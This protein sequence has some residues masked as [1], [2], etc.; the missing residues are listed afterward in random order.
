MASI[1]VEEVL[2][3]LSNYDKI[4]LLAG[5]DFWHTKA[6]PQHGVP[7]LRMTDGPNG[8]RGP[9]FFNGVPAACFPCGTALG[10]LWDQDLLQQAGYLMGEETKAKGAHVILGPTINMQR[11]PLGGRGFES[12]SEDPV[13]AGLAAAS[14]IRGIQRTGVAA[15]L[16]HFVCN[17]QEHG[18]IAYDALIT[19]RALR[20]IYL[21]P[22]Q[23]AIRDSEPLAIMT[24]YNKV[25]GLHN[26]ENPKIMTETLRDEWGWEGAIMSD[27][28]GTYS[29]SDSVNAGLDLEMPGPTKWRGGIL[30]HALAANKVKMQTIDERARKVLQLVD[31]CAK[32]GV[33]ENA[34]VGRLPDSKVSSLLRRCAAESIV[35]LKNFKKV[36]PFSKKKPLLVIGPNAKL[37]NI[38]GGGSA[39]LNPYYAIT[40]FDG[41]KS[42][43]QADVSYVLGSYSHKELPLI[44]TQVRTAPDS[45][46][47]KSGVVFRAYNE[48]PSDKSRRPVDEITISN[49]YFLL[50]DYGCPA[51]KSSLW[52]ATVDGYY[53]AERSGT[54]EL[55]L[56]VSG[57]AQLFV[58]DKL[59]IDNATK[60][61]QGETFFGNGTVEVKGTVAMQ[62]GGT[63]HIH[64]TFASSPSSKL[65]KAGVTTFP[66]GGMRIGGA[67]VLDPEE[68]VH[69]ATEMAREA[70]Q[71]VICAGLNMDWE[72]EGADRE[73]M[74]MPGHIDA[75]ISSV[76]KVNPN[77]AVVL[78]SG[79]P[80][81][82]PWL[83]EVDTLVQAWYGGNETGN[84]IAD[85]LFGDVN[86]SG[87]LPLT[88][89]KRVQDNPAFLN[90]RCEGGRTLYGEDV[91]MGYR[92]YEMLEREVAFPF[93]HGLSYSEFG[94]SGLEVSVGE[95]T[96]TVKVQLKNVGE[97][98][99]AVTVQVYVKQEQ[100]SI[101]RPPKELKGFAKRFLRRGESQS[102]EVQVPLKY[103][104]SYWDEDRDAW[105]MERGLYAVLLGT[106]SVM[107]KG[108][109]E[110]TFEIKETTWWR[111]L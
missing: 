36:L 37:A 90:Y 106:S 31:H 13:L 41:I 91:Y 28:F 14:L 8:A 89:P 80:C 87:K 5:I 59:I 99:G 39:S 6:L 46:A 62:E 21:A 102:V 103:A 53:T 24:A 34:E 101:R 35:L 49:T 66:N 72:S 25:N 85:V 110:G 42:K 111:G 64:T 92:W 109:L 74:K 30:E 67:W 100:P 71:V 52:Y 70:E 32:S 2:S 29:T 4:R 108:S 96:L 16:K 76:A 105:I 81:E 54:Y 58:D 82:M 97:V 12:Y 33:P 65:E 19:E 51:L 56:C 84:A 95:S 45:S 26:S 61:K 48:P 75:L 88:F 77:V 63:Y 73:D 57:T 78:Q 79:T 44:G 20:E 43:M 68:E 107:G 22:F 1:N 3:Q 23:I 7:S 50:P 27:W 17:D 10:A 40:P 11:S 38:C 94:L 104:A 86:P 69:R 93:G 15:T 83:E 98:D 18:R 60:Q 55:G 47:T 9:R